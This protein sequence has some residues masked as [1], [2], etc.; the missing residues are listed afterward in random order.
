MMSAAEQ[1]QQQCRR[2]GLRLP[3]GDSARKW[4]IENPSGRRGFGL[5]C[6]IWERILSIEVLFFDICLAWKCIGIMSV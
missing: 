2:Y 3:V 5:N 6:I 4:I 1:Y